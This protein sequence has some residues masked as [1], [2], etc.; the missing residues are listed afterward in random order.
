MIKQGIDISKWQDYSD[1]KRYGQGKDFVILRAGYGKNNI[2]SKFEYFKKVV[3]TID[4]PCHWGIYW[5]SYATTISEAIREAEY[6]Y[7]SV[8]ST[9]RGDV[10]KPDYPIYFDLEYDSQAY[11]KKQTGRNI[12]KDEVINFTKAFCDRLEELGCYAGY[13]CNKDYY[14][15]YYKD[16]T[17][18]TCWLADY[19]RKDFTG[20]ADNIHMIQTGSKPIDTDI[21]RVDFPSIIK[22]NKLNGYK[23]GNNIEP[24]K[25]SCGCDC[26]SKE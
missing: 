10:Y 5:F 20:L 12:T 15:R 19:T 16:L 13:Y 9:E 21:C 17:Q 1:A 6:A 25:C 23:Q 26:C 24:P 8:L 2:D 18:Y 7:Y 11:F 3:N 14:N 4:M 22:N